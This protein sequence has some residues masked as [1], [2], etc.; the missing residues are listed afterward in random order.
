MVAGKSIAFFLLFAIMYPVTQN[1]IWRVYG[2][3]AH[4]VEHLICTEEA[5]GSSP[6]RSTLRCTFASKSLLSVNIGLIF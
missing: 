5:A 1:F 4:L 2:P 6:V 3:V